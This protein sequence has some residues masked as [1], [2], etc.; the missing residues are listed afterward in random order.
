MTLDSNPEDAARSAVDTSSTPSPAYSRYVLGVLFTLYA[1]SYIDRQLMSVLLEP[2]KNEMQ[3]SDTAM[4]FL[5]GIAFAIF[6]VLMGI[7][8]A[9][10]SDRGSRR[11]I[12]SLS[13]AAWSLM[14]AA[15]GLATSYTHLLVARIGVGIGEAGGG[16]PSHSLISDYFPPE[17]RATA[18]GILT[19]GGGVGITL[20]L[21]LGGWL[22][23]LYGWRIAFLVLGLPGVLVALLVRLTVRE[24]VRGGFDSAAVRE[25]ATMSEDSV[26]DVV[27]FMWG[28]RSF[29]YL[30]F[31]ATL[32][33]FAGFGA[34]NWNPAFLMRVHG[35][36]GTEVG[37]WLGPIA[38]GCAGAGAIF[39]GM[40]TDRLGRRDERWY[41]WIPA[42]GSLCAMPFAYA[43]IL[44]P[45]K[46][47]ALLFLIPAAFIGN[48]YT[49]ATF[50]MTQGLARPHMRTLAAAIIL[51]VM[52]LLGLGLGPFVLGVM[53]DVLE[54]RFG[55]LA[56][57]YSLL[58]I[59]LPHF[60]ASV[61]NVLAAR[62]LR[63][64]LAASRAVG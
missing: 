34:S 1:V 40:F 2:I 37:L 56:I 31:A 19:T 64:D 6:Y 28:H 7:P 3:V 13:V 52:N 33:V 41:M 11:N 15:T 29:R 26:W 14:T 10:W 61:F 25:H 63:E 30:S 59:A 58:L 49:G 22:G 21:L 38:G 51:F 57:R 9:R 60:L 18:L 55:V 42:V 24:P 8:I 36:S 45:E 48:C 43:F 27:R 50:A 4:G 62:T 12:I 39:W 23:D 20:G 17:R 35:M 16:A 54:P 44:I 53:N 5:T 32:H 46:T 47:T